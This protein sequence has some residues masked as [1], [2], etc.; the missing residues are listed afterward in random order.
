[1]RDITN[2]MLFSR[3][4]K[5]GSISAAARELGMPKSTLS[6]R[7]TDLEQDQ[8]VKLLHRGT[9]QLTLTDVGREF[10]VHCQAI[11][12]AAEAASEVTKHLLETPRGTIKVSCPYAISQSLMARFLPDFMRKYPEVKVHLVATNRPVN[13][14]E[15]GVDVALRV[16]A[17]IE[18]SA[19]I[20]RPISPAPTTLYASPDFVKATTQLH[21]PLD[22][23]DQD[24]LSMHYSSGRYTYTLQHASGEQIQVSHQPKL[25]TDDMWVLREAALASQ[26]IAALPEYLCKEPLRQG[27]LVRVLPE[28]RLPTGIMHLVY[29]QRQGLLPAVR[30][31]VDYLLETLPAAATVDGYLNPPTA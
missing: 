3:V 14:I 20:A 30:V 15:E 10:L 25:I 17:S 18:D 26:G 16:R 6:R 4:V 13:L 23:I 8:G 24:T 7:L 5:A 11:D 21:H 28:W 19:F 9:R 2:L 31:F 27:R 1:M 12:A 22:L 29:T